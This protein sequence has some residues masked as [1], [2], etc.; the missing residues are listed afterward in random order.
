MPGGDPVCADAKKC[1]D[2]VKAC[3]QCDENKGSCAPD[4]GILNHK[5]LPEPPQ[6]RSLNQNEPYIKLAGETE[7]GKEMTKDRQLNGTRP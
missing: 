4:A 1:E 2:C 5:V 7:R 3:S 6:S